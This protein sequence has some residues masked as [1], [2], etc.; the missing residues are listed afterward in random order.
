MKL[1]HTQT[2]QSNQITAYGEN[3]IEINGTPHEGNVIVT[4][5]Q[6]MSWVSV[7]FEGLTEADFASLLALKP[8]VVLL[9]TGATLRFPHPRLTQALT[10]QQIGVEAMDTGAAC[11]TFNV[12]VAEDREVALA[13]LHR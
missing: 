6:V 1:H 2:A 12:L 9:G 4:A 11:R 7:G 8:A 13:I 5:S 10:Q 3:F